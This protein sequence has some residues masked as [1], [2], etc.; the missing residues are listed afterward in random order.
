M[1]ASTSVV[2]SADTIDAYRIKAVG[3]SALRWRRRLIWPLDVL[4]QELSGDTRSDVASVRQEFAALT[5]DLAGSA[6]SRGD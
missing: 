2:T 6:R 4:V 3:V 5:A 1:P